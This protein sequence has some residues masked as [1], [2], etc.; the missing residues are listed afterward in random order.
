[1][2]TGIN[3]G[4]HLVNAGQ[5][6]T[7]EEAMRLYTASNGWFFREEDK[8][9]SIEAGKFGDL[10]VLS[11]DYFEP[12]SARYG[13]PQIAVRSHGGGRQGDLPRAGETVMGKKVC[14]VVGVGPGNG[15]ALGRR[16]AR[17]AMRWHCS[18]E[19]PPPAG[20]WPPLSQ[21]PAP[22]PAM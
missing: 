17:K 2:V 10:V 20:H 13:D 16:F 21:M 9:G 11:R 3:A 7:R 5:T 22:T 18:P 1:M 8:I 14:A 4:G 6:V 15:A 12:E 19:R